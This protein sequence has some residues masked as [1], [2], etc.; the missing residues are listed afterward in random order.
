MDENRVE[1]SFLADILFVWIGWVRM[2]TSSEKIGQEKH[3]Y[4]NKG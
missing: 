4:A 1:Y 3:T 2:F